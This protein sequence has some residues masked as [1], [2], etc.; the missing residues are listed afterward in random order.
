M[1]R[2]LEKMGE[3]IYSKGWRDLES[4][5]R[6]RERQRNKSKSRRHQEIE[7]LV[8]ERRQQRK[9]WEKATYRERIGLETL[10]SKR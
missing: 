9:Q 8:K 7:N 2:R 5:A 6:T 10:Q 3:I 1:E 4:E